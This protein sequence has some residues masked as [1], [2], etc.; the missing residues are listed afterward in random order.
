MPLHDDSN[1]K[2]IAISNTFDKQLQHILY[3]SINITQYTYKIVRT[4]KFFTIVATLIAAGFLVLA[5]T[6]NATFAQTRPSTSATSTSS[7]SRAILKLQPVQLVHPI[8][9]H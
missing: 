4:T 2:R 5:T 7:I 6:S 1:F 3:H 8:A 9:F